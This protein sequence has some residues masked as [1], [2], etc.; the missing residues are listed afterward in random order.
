MQKPDD[1]TLIAYLD[2]ELDSGARREIESWLESD[3]ALRDR[4]AALAASAEALRAAFEPVL[5]EPVPE[6]LLAAARDP[7]SAAVVDFAATQKARASRRLI[8]RPWA[9]WAAAAGVAGLLVGGGAGYFAGGRDTVTETPAN[10]SAANWLDNIAG[11]HKLLI[12]A[13]AD[14][15]ALVDVPPNAN[16]PTRKVVQKLPSDFKLPNLK[17]WGLQFQGARYL[18]IDG[19]PATQLFY[20][21]DNKALGPLTVVIG[22]TT[23]SDLAPTFDRRGDLNMLYWRHHG[24]AYALVGTADIGYLWNISNDIE[25]QLDAI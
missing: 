2:S 3:A 11:Y 9:R 25:Y 7:A 13:G 19:Q 4:V 20:T 1:E 23:K 18:V 15:Q 8:E 21:T 14:D 17:P 10:L 22:A 5:H 24:H 6:R 16:D 12:N